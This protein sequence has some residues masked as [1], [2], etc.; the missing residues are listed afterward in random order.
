MPLAFDHL[1]QQARALVEAGNPS[2]ARALLEDAVGQGRAGL[3]EGDPELLETMRQLAGLHSAA[4]DPAGARRVLEEAAAAARGG[5]GADPLV[6][7]LAFDLAVV[8]EE[9]ANRHV[10]RRNFAEVADLG[11]AALGEDHWVVARARDYLDAAAPAVSVS[12]SPAPASAQPASG[13]PTSGAPGVSPASFSAP[14]P[15][16]PL[17]SAPP[18]ASAPPS[19]ARRNWLPAAL[20]GV[21]GGII[22][23]VVVAVL[24]VRPGDDQPESTAATRPAPSQPAAA[25]TASA[26]ISALPQAPV[27][28]SAAASATTAPPTPPPST[29]T[30]PPAATRTTPPAAAVRTRIVGPAANSRV[31]YPFDA[32]FTVSPADVKSTNTV[33]ALLICVAGRCY[34]DGKLDIIGNGAAPY[35]IYLGSTRPEGAGVTW[36]LRLDRLPKATYNDLIDRRDAAIADG[37]WGD[38]GTPMSA[39]NATPVSTLAVVKG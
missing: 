32:R 3:A 30:A 2:A 33:V 1:R 18:L 24:L 14:A 27:V 16:P 35:T 34:L 26:A 12:A 36:R 5:A 28:P 22:V 7:M 25:P 13:V 10:A 8:A 4:G 23:A 9:L 11:P 38:K 19:S 20:G 29:A 6:V 31:P 17:S 39:L 15:V 21:A 37:T